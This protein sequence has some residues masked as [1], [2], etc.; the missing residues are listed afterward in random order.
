MSM[1]RCARSTPSSS[2]ASAA[3]SSRGSD[4]AFEERT[5][6]HVDHCRRQQ[7][8]LAASV[9]LPAMLPYPLRQLRAVCIA[10][11]LNPKVLLVPHSRTGHRL[12]ASLVR[13]GVTWTQ[14]RVTTVVDWA[15]ESVQ[16][17]VALAG[18]RRLSSDDQWLLVTQTLAALPGA[19]TACYG[20][21]GSS[22]ATA[23]QRSLTDLR[24][25]GVEADPL[26]AAGD[27]KM[28]ALA[29]LLRDYEQRL[30]NGRW[31]DE[32]Q[33]LENATRQ[34][35]DHATE[36]RV[37]YLIL[38]ETELSTR[39]AEFVLAVAG[40][41]LERIGR[42][43]YGVQAPTSWAHACL[44][45]VELVDP[46]THREPHATA[47]TR[48]DV[49]SQAAV[50]GDLFLDHLLDRSGPE[51]RAPAPEVDVEPG[52][53]LLTTGLTASDQNR[54]RLWQ[55]TGHESEIRGVIRDVLDRQLSFDEVEIVYPPTHGNYLPL[56]YDAVCRF[57]LPAAFV[58]G[59]P[60]RMTGVGRCL[61]A[62]FEWIQELDGRVLVTALRARDIP[63]VNDEVSAAQ[64][65]T[66]LL[67]GRVDRG[68]SATMEA[69][70][71]AAALQRESD[72]PAEQMAERRKW[73]CAR[74]S[75]EM[76]ISHV[77]EASEV[78]V[79]ALAHGALALLQAVAIGLADT[80]GLE[81]VQRR[82]AQIA[83]SD[84]GRDDGPGPVSLQAQR[85]SQRLLSS[86]VE[87]TQPEPGQVSITPLAEAGYAGREHVYV[88]GLAE[89]HFPAPS[90]PDS[91]LGDTE[92]ARWAMPLPRERGQ[93]D[94][95][96]LIRLLGVSPCVTLSAHRLALAD[97]REP[98][99]TPLYSR[100]A[101]QLDAEPIWQRPTTV[102]ST[103][104]DDLERTL[105]Q[106]HRPSYGAAVQAMYPATYQGFQA[107]LARRQGVTRFDGW[108][109]SQ[110]E[111]LASERVYSAR[112]L[113]TLAQCPRRWL[114]Q[115]GLKL[116]A[117]DEPP[118]DPRRWLQPVEMGNLLHDLFADFMRHLQATHQVPDLAHEK[119]LASMVEEA[120]TQAQAQIPVTLQ[121]A[122]GNDRRRI[123]A[124]SRVFL[125]AE[126]ERFEMAG[127][128]MVDFERD[129]GGSDAPVQIQLGEWVFSLRGR[130]DRIDRVSRDDTDAY[131][132]WDYKTGSTFGFDRTD[133]LAG[134]R[135]LQWAL[136]GLALQQLLGQDAHVATSGYFFTSDRGAGQRF[137]DTP[138][139][140]QELERV[141]GPLLRMLDHGVFPAFHKGDSDPCRFCDYRR[142]C[143]TEAHGDRDLPARRQTMEQ[144]TGLVEGWADTKAAG[145][146]QASQGIESRLAEVGIRIE[147]IGPMESIDQILAWMAS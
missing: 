9:I 19:G 133:L 147:D 143:A 53:R 88:L 113:E 16:V 119:L 12:I 42:V 13:H 144:W 47:E 139:S 54:I 111:G 117:P 110:A 66:W 8:R 112:M 126:V 118:R 45:Q 37:R 82:L 3:A 104:C 29:D 78:T 38:D 31:W 132:I 85:L 17:D 86:Q 137:A 67:Q 81:A 116:K 124:A 71:R 102:T 62:Y 141:L 44:E 75:L 52:G 58:D 95:L 24:L 83:A 84:A 25:A 90:S 20:T 23:L 142:I 96:H 61:C 129:F 89:S 131:E 50:Q 36:T 107:D 103:G 40:G 74:E 26:A 121:A 114:W 87:A 11:P 22:T 123:E 70:T 18:G 35:Q 55:A 33:L 10:E 79:C 100:A 106:R 48:I 56:L 60:T 30:C 91:A 146:Q 127:R 69:L 138:P 39:A 68:R 99:P 93:A 120:V 43:D 57:D 51:S 108:I 32:A 49:R 140:P 128:Q 1:M 28:K 59:V 4:D 92:R 145:R 80:T 63:W 97:G 77:P 136:Y 5:V 41:N 27:T 130:I 94:T 135:R 73:Q 46:P 101:R 125:E 98:Y 105:S 14:L 76:L 122:F 2:P 134:G 34:A 115:D 15:W 65:T 64:V 72:D 6:I 7:T 109:G 21:L